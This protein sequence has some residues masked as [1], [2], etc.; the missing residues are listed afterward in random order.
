MPLW[1]FHLSANRNGAILHREMRYGD[2]GRDAVRLST[3]RAALDML[4]E[5]AAA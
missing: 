3:V 2:I 1:H 4:K 5:I